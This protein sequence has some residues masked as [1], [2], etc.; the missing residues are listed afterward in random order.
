MPDP[1]RLADALTYREQVLSLQR[2]HGLP[3]PLHAARPDRL[4]RRQ[5]PQGG[6]WLRIGCHHLCKCGRKLH[7]I[8]HPGHQRAPP[9][10]PQE[11][12]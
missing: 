11:I 10:F 6:D 8:P 12:L 3:L 4:P 5:P 9:Y 7:Q 2:G 1:C